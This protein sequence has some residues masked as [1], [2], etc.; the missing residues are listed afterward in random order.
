MYFAFFSWCPTTLKRFPPLPVPALGLLR[1]TA[2][3]RACVNR[4]STF[5]VSIGEGGDWS[6][7]SVSTD[8]DVDGCRSN[9]STSTDVDGLHLSKEHPGS[10]L[11]ELADLK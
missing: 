8:V 6:K 3:V 9:E 4:S 5:S 1:V 10:N 11:A 2:G 7:D